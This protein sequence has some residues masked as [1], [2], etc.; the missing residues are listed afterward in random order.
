MEMIF[1]FR[2]AEESPTT[3]ESSASDCVRKIKRTAERPAKE[4]SHS[5]CGRFFDA[6]GIQVQDMQVAPD[7][8]P[9]TV[10][11]VRSVGTVSRY[12][13]VLSYIRMLMRRCH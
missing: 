9:A 12:S 5:F 2:I 7:P 4:G 13:Y 3:P 11:I 10:L 6:N 8:L 1:A